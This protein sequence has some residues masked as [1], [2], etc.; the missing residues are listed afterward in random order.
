MDK[1]KKE[2][3]DEYKKLGCEFVNEAVCEEEL[4]EEGLDEEEV[5]KKHFDEKE[6]EDEDYVAEPDE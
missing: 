6:V 3:R 1:K 4:D 2:K 5:E